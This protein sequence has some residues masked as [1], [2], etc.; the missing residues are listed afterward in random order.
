MSL[1]KKPRN[2]NAEQKKRLDTLATQTERQKQAVLIELGK[3]PVIQAA[4][5][6]VGVGRATFYSWCKEDKEFQKRALQVR[7]EGQRFINDLAES[8]LIR[9]MQDGV[10]TAIIYWLK[11]HHGDY[12]ERY[13]HKHDHH[14]ELDLARELDSDERRQIS[15]A[16]HHIGLGNILKMNGDNIT[17][18]EFNKQ[19][20]EKEEKRLRTLGIQ[21]KAEVEKT[22]E[23]GTP[24]RGTLLRDL[25]AEEGANEDDE[26]PTSDV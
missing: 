3:Y 11:H 12:E 10:I 15:Q 18:E 20:K 6:K 22:S 5:A 13:S 8:Q 9:L 4:V 17:V 23:N 24:R 19:R 2:R 16:L 7:L 21:P 1:R 25:L 26:L 14:H